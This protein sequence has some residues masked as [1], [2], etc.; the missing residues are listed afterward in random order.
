[1]HALN[2]IEIKFADMLR[3]VQ[4]INKH[5]VFRSDSMSE[6]IKKLLTVIDEW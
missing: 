3:R 4:N 1:M 5:R 2:D 6:D